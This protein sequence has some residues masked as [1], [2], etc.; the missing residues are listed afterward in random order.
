M[1]SADYVPKVSGWKIEKGMIELNV[2]PHG[3]I[4]IGNLEE[5]EAQPDEKLATSCQKKQG[6][7]GLFIVVDGAHY[8]NQALV[9]DFAIGARINEEASARAS[10]DEALANRI[11]ALE[12]RFHRD[13][14]S[15][16][17]L[18]DAMA[19]W[20]P[21]IA[22]LGGQC[23]VGAHQFAVTMAKNTNGDYV[24][25]GIGLGIDPCKGETNDGQTDMERT[26]EKGDAAE[27]LRMIG[28]QIT[29]SVLGQEL[30]KEVEKIS[31]DF[32]GS[33]N[34][35]IDAMESVREVIRKELRPGGILHRR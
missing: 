4:R 21:G 18:R 27:V 9:D 34:G 11:G 35:R 19:D 12:D 29:E 3:Q 17:A 10:A 13:D 31:G 22:L 33:V 1:Q 5:P 26:I 23:L 32:P 15:D 20:K 28:G 16:G 8:I 7:V 30:L 24:C 2:G 6:L 25:T 14:T